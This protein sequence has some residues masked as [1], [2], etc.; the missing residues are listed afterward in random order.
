MYRK[1][2][3]LVCMVMLLAM[4]GLAAAQDEDTGGSTEMRAVWN[5]ETLVL[6]NVGQ[7]GADLTSTSLTSADGAITPESWVMFVDEETTLSFPLSD[8]RPGDCLQVYLSGTEATP[9]DTVSCTRVVGEFT[10]TTFDDLVWDVTQGGFSI[11]ANGAETACD[12]TTTSCDFTAPEGSEME[13]TDMVP[14]NVT[15]RAIWNQDIFVL[16]NV[17]EFGADLSELTLS[18]ELGTIGAE[19]W[20]LLED[21]ETTEA[22]TLADVRPGS[23]LISYTG[24]EEQPELPEDVECTLTIGEFTL[25]N[26]D[27]IIWD[28]NAGGFT[29]STGAECAV[30]G[31][32][33]CDITAPTAAIEFEMDDMEEETIDPNA[34]ARAVWNQD[35]FVVINTGDTGIDLSGVSFESGS[36]GM[37]APDQWVLFEDSDTGAF[38]TLDDVRPGSCLVSYLGGTAQ[39]ELP[40]GV[41][42]TRTIGEFTPA[43]LDDIIWDVNA[44]GFSISTGATCAVEGTTDCAFTAPAL[45]E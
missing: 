5:S 31:T 16:I 8:L 19:Q 41:E 2:S 32:T 1:W 7:T 15:L 17:S 10:P 22:Y 21:P 34:N 13:M 43:N 44:G 27:D 42:C 30:D 12:I 28:V 23:C 20:V 29:A 24:G 39:P 37:I 14:E 35:I 9:P 4:S 45:E 36:G 26:L 25:E 3:L 11:T 6:I 18:S 40:S 33:T 38:F